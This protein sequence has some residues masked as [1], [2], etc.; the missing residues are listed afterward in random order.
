GALVDYLNLPMMLEKI[1]E[2]I[3]DED[4]RLQKGTFGQELIEKDFNFLDYVYQLLNL[5]E[6]NYKKISVIVPNYN[7]EK[8][9]PERVKS[10]LN[11]T[12]P[13]YELIF[14]DDAST[15]NS[16]SI[17]EK[18]LSNENKHHLK[19]QQIINDKNSGSVFKQWIKGVSAA[20]GDYIWI[21]E[22][23]DLCDQTF[24]EEV[25]QGFHIDSDVAL[26]YTQSKQIDEQGN[27]LANH[28]LN[29]TNDID[30][31]KWQSSYIRK[32]IDE[33]QDTLFI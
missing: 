15:D 30:K 11:Q 19:V 16:V 20:T 29:Y 4:L 27:I 23:D 1:Y 25:I 9:L 5:L 14:L 17:F 24:L 7:Y 33:I 28:Y 3:G 22:A 2:F 10:I 8:Y 26:S 12:Y 13:L 31:E 32:G 18:L 21:A 6:H